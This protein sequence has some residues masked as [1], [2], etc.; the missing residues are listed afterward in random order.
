M[1]THEKSENVTKGDSDVEINQ[2]AVTAGEYTVDKGSDV[3]GQF[4]AK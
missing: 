1:S 3:A 4:L 2:L